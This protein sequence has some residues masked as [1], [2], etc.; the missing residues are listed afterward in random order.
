M[1]TT[2]RKFMLGLAGLGTV[3][4]SGEVLGAEKEFINDKIKIHCKRIRNNCQ[5]FINFEVEVEANNL[6][7]GEYFYIQ[8]NND[9]KSHLFKVICLEYQDGTEQIETS[10]NHEEV[11]LSKKNRTTD[12]NRFF[13][14][15]SKKY[16][17]AEIVKAKEEYRFWSI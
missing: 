12:L 11:E 1:K 5:H 3:V 15:Y 14:V 10:Q 13:D 17:S 9:W 16:I 2:R 7:V 8:P 4:V 6:E